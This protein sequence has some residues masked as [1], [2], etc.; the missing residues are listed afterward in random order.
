MV[1][2]HQAIRLPEADTNRLL[3]KHPA[4]L[5]RGK[6]RRW[7]TLADERTTTTKEPPQCSNTNF[8]TSKTN[9]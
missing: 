7:P 6:S 1:R 3:M 4:S 5:K 9:S 8:M 2:R